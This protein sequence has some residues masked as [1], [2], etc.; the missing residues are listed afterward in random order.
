[1]STLLLN[2]SARGKGEGVEMIIQFKDAIVPVHTYYFDLA[3]PRP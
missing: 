3:S 2:F 1:M